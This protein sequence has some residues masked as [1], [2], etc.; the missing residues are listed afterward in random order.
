MDG[1]KS[2]TVLWQK[3]TESVCGEKSGFESQYDFKQV[4]L[5]PSW[6]YQKKE[7]ENKPSAVWPVFEWQLFV[8]F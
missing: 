6:E 4:A 1:S 7:T 3:V 2:R 5:I 8:L